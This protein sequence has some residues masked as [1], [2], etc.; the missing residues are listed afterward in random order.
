MEQHVDLDKLTRSTRRL[1]FEDGLNDFQNA[2]IFVILGGLA[3]LF[4]SSAGIRLYVRGMLYNQEITVIML[5]A[6][7]AFLVLLM[8]GMR[9]W[10]QKYR[11][12]VLWREMGEMEPFRW[13][14]DSKVNA[15]ATLVWL[16][17]V[18]GGFILLTRNPMDLDAGMRIIAGAG[19][20]ATGV[21]YLGMGFSL[22]LRRY[23]WVG[24]VGGVLSAALIVTPFN[25]SYSWLALGILWFVVLAVSGLT[26]FRSTQERLRER[27]A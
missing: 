10:I 19:G 18:I 21:V 13:Q 2:L 6:M 22:S 25:V 23:R 15:I 17:V 9:R 4:M 1:E 11:R 8:F 20:I 5:V 3:S 7:I 12:E 14:V 26:A 16:V 27:A 24:I